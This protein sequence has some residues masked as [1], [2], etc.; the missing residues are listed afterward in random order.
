L[1]DDKKSILSWR[2]NVNG[3]DRRLAS[4]GIMG[5]RRSFSSDTATTPEGWKAARL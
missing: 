3:Y 4:R 1:Q 5:S 2:D